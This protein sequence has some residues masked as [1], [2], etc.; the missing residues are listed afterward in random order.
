METAE[1]ARSR[2]LLSRRGLLRAGGGGLLIGVALPLLEACTPAIPLVPTAGPASAVPTTVAAKPALAPTTGASG[3]VVTTVPAKPASAIP[4][5]FAVTSGPKPDF[6]SSGPQYEDGFINYPRPN[7]K[8][9]LKEPPGLGSEIKVFSQARGVGS[10]IPPTPFDSNPAWQEV[11][12]QLNANVQFTTAPSNDYNTKLA[13]IMAGNEL[14]D[15][16]NFPGGLGTTNATATSSTRGLPSFLQ[17]RMADLTPFLAGDAI[18]EYPNLAAI[19]TAAWKN[20]GCIYNGQILMWPV[21]RYR[22]F[23]MLFRNVDMWDK[24]LGSGFLPQNAD[25]FKR[26][27]LQI[28]RPR[29]GHYGV[30]GVNITYNLQVFGA[31]FGAP[32]GWSL[33]SGGKLTKD[34]ETPQFKEAV[35]F[36]RDLVT[37]GVYVPDSITGPSG[38]AAITPFAQGKGALI[39]YTFG[40]NWTTLWVTC[41]AAQ[42]QVNF[43]PLGLFPAHDGGKLGHYLSPGFIVT[44]AMKKGPPERIKE[45]LRIIDWLAAPFGS[46]EDL[47]LTFGIEG[48][49]YNVDARGLPVQTERGPA[50]SQSVPWQ[51]IVQHNQV[52]F[53]PGYADYAK[54]AYEAEHVLIPAGIDDPTWGLD[55]P[56]YGS[57]GAPITQSVNDTLTDIVVGRRE[58][59]E[60]DTMVAD[61]R[62]KGGDQIRNELE[63]AVA[64]AAA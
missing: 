24:E 63:R 19:P 2:L 58:M 6:A 35:A 40:V 38:P 45:M 11:N 57:L 55:S 47:L 13:A 16:V 42:P 62:S 10:T 5:Y 56:T 21:Q 12:K 3:A 4:G 39:P 31:T 49:D 64:A 29:E 54:L 17:T 50:D 28:N 52:M 59:S 14:P 7:P 53:F 20:S 41:Q 22:P 33:D 32:N 27:L 18:K 44:N 8:S 9:L 15:I 61:W 48:I 51:Y 26:A 23:A 43:L 46:Q 1:P 36:L 34:I 60:Y 30:V 25:D 37:A